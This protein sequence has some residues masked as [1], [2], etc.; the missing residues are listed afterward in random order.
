LLE[1]DHPVCSSRGISTSLEDI[2]EIHFGGL[3]TGKGPQKYDWQY[4]RWFLRYRNGKPLEKLE[5]SCTHNANFKLFVF[6]ML[7]FNYQRKL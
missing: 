3:K 6:H 5:T 4:L 1:L 2:P 7:L